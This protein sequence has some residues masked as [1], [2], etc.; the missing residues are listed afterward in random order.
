MLFRSMF[1]KPLEYEFTEEGITV[2]QDEMEA[3]TK[4]DEIAKAVGTNQSVIL[5]LNRVRAWIFPKECMGEQYVEILKM[6][7]THIPPKRV[8]IRGV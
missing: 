8:K 2:R 5:Y 1:Q 7:H 6:I 4:W 3:T